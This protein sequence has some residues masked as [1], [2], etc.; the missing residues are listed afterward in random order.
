MLPLDWVEQNFLE[1]SGLALHGAGGQKVVYS[2]VHNTDGDVVLKL[3]SPATPTSTIEREVLAVEQVQSARVP[4][5]IETGTIASPIGDCIWIREQRI[6]GNTLREQLNHGAL[7]PTALLTLTYQMLLAL[8]DAEKANIVHRDVKPENIMVDTN[9]DYWLLD[10]GIARH[11]SMPALTA[12]VA[13]FGKFTVGYAPVEQFRNIQTEIDSRA[14]LFALGVTIHECSS[15]NH[16]FNAGAS[17]QLAA[18]RN[19][20]SVALPKLAVPCAKQDEFG[21]LIDTMTKKRRDQRI[22]SVAEATAWMREIMVA[23]SLTV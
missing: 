16:P 19:V 21:D 20:E 7:T 1:I 4:R 6:L 15:G 8:A 18:L 3:L 2:G 9:E 14:D 22:G 13:M 5:I 11:L 23:E 10:F 17:D 12:T